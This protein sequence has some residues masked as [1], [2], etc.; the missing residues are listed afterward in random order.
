[1]AGFFTRYMPYVISD[2]VYIVFSAGRPVNI[3]KKRVY[4]I[5]ENMMV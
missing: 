2:V 4:C 5:I 3:L 1:M